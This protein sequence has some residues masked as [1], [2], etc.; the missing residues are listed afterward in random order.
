MTKKNMIKF[1]AEM[2]AHYCSSN[3]TGLK[4]LY[5]DNDSGL[6]VGVCGIDSSQSSRPLAPY[7]EFM[8]LLKGEASIE[9]KLTGDVYK[10]KTTETFVVPSS[11]QYEW[12]PS[13]SAIKLFFNVKTID[14]VDKPLINISEAYDKDSSQKIDV[15]L[16]DDGFDLKTK[17]P[18]NKGQHLFKSSSGHFFS[19][20]WQSKQLETHPQAFPRNELIYIKS[21]KLICIDEHGIE[22]LFVEG[23]ALFIPKG[24]ICHWRIEEDVGTFYAV[25]Q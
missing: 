6:T 5:Q 20:I 15:Q 12:Q 9:N 25:L 3:S 21:G 7:D 23:D 18:V 17:K 16:L 4:V 2:L 22:H 11:Q 14:L 1:N 24:V 13:T 19:G 8:I 10:I